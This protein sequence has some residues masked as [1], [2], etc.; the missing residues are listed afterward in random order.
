L[1]EVEPLELGRLGSGAIPGISTDRGNS[2]AEAAAV[3]LDQNNHLSG[4]N[5]VSLNERGQELPIVWDEV[6][7]QAKRSW[8]DL[9]EA[10]EDGA[11][12]IGVLLIERFTAFTCIERA[13]QGNG[14]DWWLG[15]K[16]EE[17]MEFPFQYKRAR[18]ENSG[19]LQGTEA[20]VRQRANEKIRR[21]Q[22]Y[23]NRTPAEVV[24][25]E[26][27]RPSWLMESV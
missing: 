16:E 10:T 6:S 15:Y 9:K 8:G 3:C 17:D 7:E 5:L 4:V 2:F 11:M 18:L 23:T 25:V 12:G 19:I 24:I 14:N 1:N 22:S 13:P 20:Q 27:G 21:I 26:F